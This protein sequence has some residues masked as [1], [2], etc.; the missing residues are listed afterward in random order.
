MELHSAN[1]D[2]PPMALEQSTEV[3]ALAVAGVVP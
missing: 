2:F 3:E 1:P